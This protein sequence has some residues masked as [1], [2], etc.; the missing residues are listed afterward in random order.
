MSNSTQMRKSTQDATQETMEALYTTMMHLVRGQGYYVS[1]GPTDEDRQTAYSQMEALVIGAG[2]FD[3]EALVGSKK[4]P[5]F[6][7]LTQ[8]HVIQ[9]SA[10]WM[11]ILTSHQKLENIQHNGKSL[12]AM[13][14][15]GRIIPDLRDPGRSDIDVAK[16]L[17]TNTADKQW[18]GNE[19]GEWAAKMEHVTRTEMHNLLK[20]IINR[21]YVAK[22][23]PSRTKLRWTGATDTAHATGISLV[24]MVDMPS[25]KQRELGDVWAGRAA[26]HARFDKTDRQSLNKRELPH[27]RKDDL[28]PWAL[29]PALTIDEGRARLWSAIMEKE[30]VWGAFVKIGLKSKKAERN[31]RAQTILNAR[32][33]EGRGIETILLQAQGPDWHVFKYTLPDF[34]K[35]EV[36]FC[37]IH[38]RGLIEQKLDPRHISLKDDMLSSM[39]FKGIDGKVSRQDLLGVSKEQQDSAVNLLI[40]LNIPGHHQEDE[41]IR[42][43]INVATPGEAARLGQAA[44]LGRA[45]NEAQRAL[46]Y[47]WGHSGSGHQNAANFKENVLRKWNEALE[48][49]IVLDIDSADW[50]QWREMFLEPMLQS[51]QPSWFS[52]DLK[53]QL[54]VI[55]GK[56][57]KVFALATLEKVVGGGEMKA[58]QRL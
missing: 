12:L 21:G 15:N 42:A 4:L 6:V 52:D 31:E 40:D 29:D 49:P 14:M 10:S 43:A 17:L 24:E 30:E 57:N 13:W 55:L 51:G 41:A 33:E 5:F 9:I 56:G 35:R 50:Q 44:I 11:A 25:G 3:V 18:D 28:V 22:T 46:L 47:N 20:I 7:A 58:R 32:D 36:S 19:A 26:M 37:D 8:N 34:L 48:A 23:N 53:E 54:N 16:W 27:H 1:G 2:R 39:S 45:I 38:G